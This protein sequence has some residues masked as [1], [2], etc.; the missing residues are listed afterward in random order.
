MTTNDGGM[1]LCLG[2]SPAWIGILFVACFLL[3][4]PG[5]ATSAQEF[6]VKDGETITI[7]LSSKELTR[8]AIQGDGRLDKVWGSAGV[9][10]IEPDKDQGEIFVRPS[11]QAPTS[12]SFFVR[13][14]L[15]G[16]YTIVATQHDIPSETIILKPAAPRKSIGRGSEYRSTPFVERVKRV[17][18][19]MALGDSIDGYSFEDLEQGVPLWAE[20]EIVLRR[21]YTGY[22]LLGE[23]YTIKNV[24]KKEMT[25]HEREFMDFG[26]EVQAVALERL[27]L[28]E[29]ES[30]FLYV[31]R[32]PVGA[33]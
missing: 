30:T 18:K 7:K 2:V 12:F 25:I 16:T 28:D 21:V 32:K 33:E 20:T 27:S 8:I 15:G 19:G 3:V 23:I 10:E 11:P 9:L 31:V 13:D 4:A 24:S 17:I 1:N 26:H 6:R 22:D 5:I 14:D 29:G